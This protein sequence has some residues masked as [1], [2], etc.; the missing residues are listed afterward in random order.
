M[1]T[2]NP[3]ITRSGDNNQIKFSYALTS[4]NPD[5]APIPDMY[6]A[7]SDRSASVKGTFG[8]GTVL[9]QGSND[10]GATYNPLT[11][12]QGNALS[13]TAVAI[14]QITEVAEMTRPLVTTPDGTTALQVD[15]V[16]RRPPKPAG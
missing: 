1:P 14:E 15:I 9:I 4:A 2:A 13:K 12:P 8:T 6:A 7:Y 3:T 11:D 16:I 5:G 10:A